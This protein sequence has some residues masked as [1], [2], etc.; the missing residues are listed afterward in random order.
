M[1][2]VAPVL[3]HPKSFGR[4]ELK[5]NSPL[6]FPIIDLNYYTDP[7][8]N[9]L[10]EMLKAFKYVIKLS[11]TPLLQSIGSEY[12]SKPLPACSSF[13]HLSDDYIKCALQQL[14]TSLYHQM[15]TVAMGSENSSNAVVDCNFRVRGVSNLRVVDVS[16]VPH[17]VAGHTNSIAYVI[18][19]KA[20][21]VIKSSFSG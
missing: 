18:G 8:N 17:P 10:D 12:I 6:D 3:Q 9:D 13:D 15:G 1:W 7:D 21:D 19:E 16:V 5:S 20:A 11:K 14:T 4:V 2:A